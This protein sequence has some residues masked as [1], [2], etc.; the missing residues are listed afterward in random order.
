MALPVLRDALSSGADCAAARRCGS[1]LI[2]RTHRWAERW[3]RVLLEF[4]QKPRRA[5]PL[6]WRGLWFDHRSA[7][8]AGKRSL[9]SSLR[10]RLLSAAALPAPSEPA[11]AMNLCRCRTTW[12]SQSSPPPATR[13]RTALAAETPRPPVRPLAM[14]TPRKRAQAP[15]RPKARDPPGN[16]LFL[17][18]DEPASRSNKRPVYK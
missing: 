16:W 14:L 8:G 10:R 5:T 13:A 1:C 17:K 2:L 9:G 4:L 12:V 18:G 6:R 11:S 15:T 3:E 7:R